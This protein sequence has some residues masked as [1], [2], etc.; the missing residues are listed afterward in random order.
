MIEFVSEEGQKGRCGRKHAKV[1]CRVVAKIK[2]KNKSDCQR[3][4]YSPAVQSITSGQTH[5]PRMRLFTT[6]VTHFHCFLHIYMFFRIGSREFCECHVL[7]RVY[8]VGQRIKNSV[9]RNVGSTETRERKKISHFYEYCNLFISACFVENENKIEQIKG[10]N[11]NSTRE[12]ECRLWVRNRSK[13]YEPKKTTSTERNTKQIWTKGG[14][15][16]EQKKNKRTA[17]FALCCLFSQLKR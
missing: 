17:C 11:S 5:R 2:H 12:K 3:G 13:R 15:G 1:G 10:A 6:V 7:D 9:E 8:H 14:R 4:I 16:V